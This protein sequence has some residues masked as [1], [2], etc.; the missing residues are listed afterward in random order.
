MLSASEQRLLIYTHLTLVLIMTPPHR[1]EVCARYSI[2][3][4]PVLKHSR[5]R[6]VVIDF[7]AV[8]VKGIPRV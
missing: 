7:L 2:N 8:G 3:N 6:S 1:V 4:S 5:V